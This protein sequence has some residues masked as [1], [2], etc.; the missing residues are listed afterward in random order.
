MTSAP[1]AATPDAPA[2]HAQTIEQVLADM[3]VTV[4]GGLSAAEAASR[5]QQ[6][7]ANELASAPATPQWV[8]FLSQFR[9]LVVLILIG[10]A[11]ISLLLQEWPDAI[12]ILTIVL[13]NAVLGF[14]QESKAEQSLAALQEMSSPSAKVIRDGQPQVAPARELVRGDI[15][16]VEAGDK[17]PADCRLLRGFSLRAQ[18]AALTGESTPVDKHH[19]EVLPTETPLADRHNMLHMGTVLALG[20][21]TA[22]VTATGMSAEL[23]SIAGMLQNRK[24]E[25]TPLQR[26]LAEVGRV[27]IVLCL[28]I[29]GLIL[30]LQLSRGQPLLEV[31]MLS[32]GLAVAAVPEGMPAV[33]TVALALGLQRMAKR[34]ALIRK[35]PSVETLGCVTVI[36]SDKTGT[37]TRNE[38]T[39]RELLVSDRHYEVSGAGYAPTGEFQEIGAAAGQDGEVPSD[40]RKLLTIGARCNHAR[41]TKNAENGAWQIIGDPTEG[42]LIVAAQKAGLDTDHEGGEI[43]HELPFDSQRK[44]M[45]AVVRNTSG[46]ATLF[47]KGAPEVI[48]KRC[49]NVLQGDTPVDLDDSTRKRMTDAAAEMANRAL[50]VLALAYRPLDGQPVE[51]GEQDERDLVLVGLA[52]MI[53][54]PRDEARK[55][56][57]TCR[58]AGIRPVMITGD[59]PATA[60]AIARELKMADENAEVVTGQQ[61]DGMASEELAERV[62]KIPVYARVSAAHKLKIIEAWQSRGQVVAM[63]GDGV[64]DAPAVKAADIGIAMGV[65]GTDVT[66]EASDMVLTDDNFASIMNA[67]EEGRGIFDNIQKF[68][69]YLLSSNCSEVLL[70]FFA[71]LVGWPSPLRAIHLLWINLVTDGLPALALT[72]EPPERNLM[73]RSP[74]PPR[75]P[76]ITRERGMRIVAHGLLMACTAGLGFWLF[77]QGEDERLPAARTATFSILAFSQLFYSLSCRSQTLTMPEVGWFSNPYLFAAIAVSAIAQIAVVILPFFQSVFESVIDFRGQWYLIPLLALAPV[78]IIELFKLVRRAIGGGMN[79]G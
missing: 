46:Q 71:A 75:E 72:M 44:A 36:C 76:V 10:A 6:Y 9:E 33:V 43:V 64:N 55:A 16:H 66:K 78:T 45:S 49:R 24:Q 59:H 14:V 41:L 5:L 8:R 48:L 29:V 2:A 70:M 23:G 20:E 47:T 13:L 32:V 39:V 65:T 34:N 4:E 52:A 68:I 73:R 31:F 74:R 37:L 60:L 40:I 62:E 11:V 35:L 28:A 22:I 56:I 1:L 17:I 12:A 58:G 26:R 69:L 30:L 15:I 19:D 67:V 79:G 42:A 7:G 54:P 38:M 18:E 57:A 51:I 25:Q 50:R 77:Y 27:L 21:G 3:G 61:L 63:T 53:D